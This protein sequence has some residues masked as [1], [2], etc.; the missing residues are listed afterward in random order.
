MTFKLAT[1]PVPLATAAALFWAGNFVAGRAINGELSPLSLSFGRW[2]LALLCLAPLAL[3]RLRGAW[4]QLKQH[5]RTVLVLG[6]L[7]VTLCNTLIY[8]GVAHTTAVNAVMLNAF[9]PI[10]VL[11]AGRMFLGQSM[12]WMQCIGSALSF[13]GVAVILTHGAPSQLLSLNLN[14]GDLWVFAA[15][16]CWALYTLT[17]RKVPTGIDK[18]AMLF[19]TILV[20]TLML[21]PA[22]IWEW[23]HQGVPT[24]SVHSAS[25][26]LFLGIFPSVLAY[27]FYNIAVAQLGAARASSFMH[28]I[29]AF[30]AM[31]AMLLLG[32]HV[33]WW[34]LAGLANVLAGVALSNGMLPRLNMPRTALR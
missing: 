5:W 1:R 8:R 18:I 9:V 26:V 29:P 4:P 13:C 25:I 15:V 22:V 16:A 6:L 34:H 30:G 28:L 2:I 3:P 33:Q 23:A 20:G 32:E 19:A 7:G 14:P 11:L 21:A 17:L 12:S 24:L 31:L 27:L 10:M